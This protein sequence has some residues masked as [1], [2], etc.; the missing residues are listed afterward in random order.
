MALPASQAEV[1]AEAPKE[2]PKAE[3]KVAKAE[4]KA[5]AKAT[6][7]NNAG[8]ETKSQK[9]AKQR[10]VK[11]GGGGESDED[12][13]ERVL[14]KV[15][16]FQYDVELDSKEDFALA[17]KLAMLERKNQKL[18]D[19]V[20]ELED[21]LFD[22]EENVSTL[23]RKLQVAEEEAT[24]FQ[25]LLEQRE[26]QNALLRQ[27][28]SSLQAKLDAEIAKKN[29]IDAERRKYEHRIAILETEVEQNAQAN[30]KLE[31]AIE[32]V[33][34]L[35]KKVAELLNQNGE[36][37]QLSERKSGEVV[38]LEKKL[39]AEMARSREH[40]NKT[41]AD[42]EKLIEAEKR[43]GQQ[44]IDYV[45]NTLKSR[46]QVLQLKLDDGSDTFASHKKE[47]RGLEKGMKQSQRIVEDQRAQSTRD[48]RRIESLE[49]QLKRSKERADEL[50]QQ[51][52]QIEGKN[53]S[54]QREVDTLKAQYDAA[55]HINA[56]LNAK[57]H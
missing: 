35:R 1:K 16:T 13:P 25:A 51:R 34:R 42:M 40:H 4:P 26:A 44:A 6:D 23:R 49:R 50:L 55:I 33:D 2:V 22:A 37:E 7:S 18:L 10:E 3:P 43:R 29:E 14:P 38:Q 21:K 20:E 9:P 39:R 8:D 45:R 5:E 52:N 31:S 17:T 53:F 41:V 19:Q 30:S 27:D 28:I 54:L 11:R 47:K 36:L 48:A 15:D 46:I 12:M 24:D 57:Y 32:E 56:K